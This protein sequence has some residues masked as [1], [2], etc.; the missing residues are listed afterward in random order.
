MCLYAMTMFVTA[1]R[2]PIQSSWQHFAIALAH[3]KFNA[4]VWWTSI[5]AH[6]LVISACH[7]TVCAHTRR[8]YV[9]AR[10]PRSVPKLGR[11]GLGLKA[12][13]GRQH[14]A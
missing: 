14:I 6:A 12:R 9:Q 13:L 8:T 5:T 11:V 7:P 2:R 1:V 4:C 10:S 3:T